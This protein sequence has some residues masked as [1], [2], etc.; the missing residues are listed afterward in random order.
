MAAQPTGGDKLPQAMGQGA[1]LDLFRRGLLEG[2]AVAVAPGGPTADAVV[3]A[4][5]A[6]GA[7]VDRHEDVVADDAAAADFAA[8]V[9]KR[10]GALHTLVVDA[11]ARFAATPTD[12]G[13]AG[14]VR[15]AADPAWALVRA[16]AVAGMIEPEA[17]G[18]VVVIAPRPGAGPRAATVRAALENLARTLSIEWSRYA[19][20]TTAILPGDSTAPEEI[21]AVV[22]FL[23]S[24]AGDYYSGCVMDVGGP[25]A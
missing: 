16:A 14:P 15:A 23:A 19:I 25:P 7:T 6:L 17:G 11:G 9:V 20:R 5:E 13:G 4:C 18:K 12:P 24:P 1:A 2:Q 8:G 10:R 21:A 3:A 22:A